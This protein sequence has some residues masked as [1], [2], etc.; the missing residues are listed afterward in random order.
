MG[1]Y[2]LTGT[3]P[4]EA[5]RGYLTRPEDRSGPLGK[6]VEAAGGTLKQLY[7]TTGET[8]FMLIIE[9]DGP[10]VPAAAAMVAGA[11][12][13]AGGFR[14]VQAWTGAEFQ[15]LTEKAAGLTE[16]YAPPGG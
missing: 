9:A 4:R 13:M 10:E 3:L 12:G 14:T 5:L 11:A 8:D 2:I 1:T 15:T 6:L 16:K 7:F